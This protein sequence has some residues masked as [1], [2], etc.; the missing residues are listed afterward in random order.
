MLN[1][2]ILI[3]ANSR[4][5]KDTLV[6]FLNDSHGITFKSSSDEANELFLFDF[7]KDKYNYSSLDEC[8]LDRVNHR[9]LW[10]NEICAYNSDNKTRL[11]ESIFTKVDC[12]VGM[13][14]LEEFQET[15]RKELVDVIIWVDASKRLPPEPIESFNIPQSFADITIDNNGTLAEF[16][17]RA[18]ELGEFL[19][20]KDVH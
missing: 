16:K 1:K 7:L 10:Y 14:D 9:T 8:F 2:K 13:R 19:T 11:A 4:H 20:K 6:E 5:G 3:I 17:Q 12:Y 15:V 18:W